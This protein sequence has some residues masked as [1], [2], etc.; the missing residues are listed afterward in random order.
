[1]D[2]PNNGGRQIDEIAFRNSAAK[3]MRGRHDH[4][5]MHCGCTPDQF[6]IVP[7]NHNAISGKIMTRPRTMII[8]TT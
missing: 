3:N 1:M 7:G 5:R 8:R 6:R 4:V 2:L